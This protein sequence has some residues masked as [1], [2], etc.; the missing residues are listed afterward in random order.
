MSESLINY[1][2]S[3]GPINPGFGS[4]TDPFNLSEGRFVTSSRIIYTSQSDGSQNYDIT[5]NTHASPAVYSG[6]YNTAN[7]AYSYGDTGSLEVKLNGETQ[8]IAYL[9]HANNFVNSDKNGDQ[10]MNGYDHGGF[11]NG[12]ASFSSD[13]GQ[14]LL[15]R[16]SPFN[17]VS[18]SISA[19]GI[20]LSNGYQGWEAT[21]NITDKPRDGYNYLEL[22]HN[23]TSSLTQSLNVFDWYYDDG[24]Y[25][26]SLE[27]TGNFITMSNAP[28]FSE[29]T[30]S[31]SGI[32]YFK[33]DSPVSASI[34]LIHHLA[35]KTYPSDEST[36]FKN[37]VVSIPISGNL[38]LKGDGSGMS[39]GKLQH[40][41]FDIDILE[42]GSN[43]RRG[44]RYHEDD[45]NYIP[46]SKSTGSILYHIE[47]S[48]NPTGT[49]RDGG[50][51]HG[52][53]VM[54]RQ[55][56]PSDLG[57]YLEKEL[58]Q[59]LIGRFMTSGSDISGY[60]AKTD[61]IETFFDEDRRWSRS[62]L[63]DL[64]IVRQL[65][66]SDPLGYSFF[67]SS[68]N[69]DYNSNQSIVATDDLQQ[70]YEG[71]LKYPSKNYSVDGGGNLIYNNFHQTLPNYDILT[72][73]SNRYYYTAL[74]FNDSDFD[75]NTLGFKVRV[76]GN[77]NEND[78][79]GRLGQGIGVD[80][81]KIRV[82][83]KIPGPQTNAAAGSGWSNIGHQGSNT[84]TLT[85]DWSSF[86]SLDNQLSASDFIEFTLNMRNRR[87]NKV[88]G[89]VLFRVRYKNT[90]DEHITKLEILPL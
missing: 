61:Q 69:A 80:D 79:F 19:S 54:G 6:D 77:F 44:L 14:L 8:F 70:T 85:D 16:V 26:S 11:T 63:E 74:R 17:G 35:S 72:S 66:T 42:P 24:F 59:K 7:K 64:S 46:T 86:S 33:V 48:D 47:S 2:E 60:E 15:N 37:M 78:I 20:I 21:I 87:I 5:F 12:T 88:D 28:S 76:H 83:I 45:G 18:Q 51:I 40:R 68:S 30:H 36:G 62:S 39:S 1:S 56:D 67:L 90:V 71:I 65:R 27:S 53:R 29:P 43:F 55:K 58:G 3:K 23:I 41:T 57:I 10:D 82:D 49:D 25:T 50:I 38:D 32:S 75:S 31:I 9:Q 73:N 89:V 22:I 4:Y 13:N 81:S 34:N 84:N 52:I